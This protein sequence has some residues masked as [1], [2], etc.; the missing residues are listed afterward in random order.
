[1]DDDVARQF[2][3]HDCAPEV[4]K[5]ALTTRSL[6]YEEEAMKEFCP[7]KAWP[8]VASSYVICREDRTISPAWSRRIAHEVLGV[9]PVEMS[10]GH[11][12]FVSRP[13]DLADV[14]TRED[15]LTS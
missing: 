5:W 13:S 10:G 7:L 9:Q 2:L 1:M 15:I 4:M 11:C 12:P 3:F 14:L 8:S 6:M